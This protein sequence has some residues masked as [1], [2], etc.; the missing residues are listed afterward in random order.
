MGHDFD[1]DLFLL[2]HDVARLIRVE[3]DKRARTYGMTRAQWV[4]LLRLSQHP[5]LSQKEAADLLEVEPIT[6]ARL[7][8]RLVALGLIERRADKQDRR[9]WRLHLLP[10]AT[11]MLDEIDRHRAAVANFVGAGLCADAHAAMVQGLQRMKANLLLAPEQTTQQAL[12][13]ET[14][15][16]TG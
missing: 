5:G 16:E 14:L 11:A 6:V 4:L 13:A 3:A 1:G 9:V 15:K 7:V 8:D 2:L 10:A 12:P